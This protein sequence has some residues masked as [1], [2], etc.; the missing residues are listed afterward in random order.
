MREDDLRESSNVEDRRGMSGAG[1]GG[2]GIGAVVVLTLIGWAT[3]IN[4]AAL[5]GGAE[6]VQQTLNPQ[7]QQA[8]QGRQG[9]PSDEMGRFVAKVLGET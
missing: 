4:P 3:G 1:K 7:Q 5:I 2:L 6:Q 9:A 8:Q